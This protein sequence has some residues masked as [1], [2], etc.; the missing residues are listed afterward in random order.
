MGFAKEFKEFAMRGNVVDL[1][2][3]V[4]IGG[5]FGKIVSSLVEDIITPAILTPAL[6]AANLK[7]LSELVIPGTAIKYGNFLSQV[8]SFIIV[9]FALFLI[10][11][12]INSL[13]KKEEAAPSAPPVPSKEEVLLAEIRDILKTK[14]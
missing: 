10:I 1:A 6:E 8:I 7:N 3:G 14:N 13:K 4:I 5:A 2:V 12:G 11:K 9:A